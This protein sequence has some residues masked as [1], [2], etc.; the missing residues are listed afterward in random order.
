[1]TKQEYADIYINTMNELVDKWKDDPNY[2]GTQATYEFDEIANA[3]EIVGYYV[4]NEKE[5][6]LKQ[7][8]TNTEGIEMT[9]Q[10]KEVTRIL[11]ELYGR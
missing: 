8:L 4:Y 5:N 6:A 9:E 10:D 3:P 1:M 2:D 11:E 7:W